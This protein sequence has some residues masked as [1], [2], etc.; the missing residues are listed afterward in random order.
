VTPFQEIAGRGQAAFL[1]GDMAEAERLFREALTHKPMSVGGMRGLGM[2]LV[3][4]SKF[5]EAEEVWRK[6]VELE[7][8][9]ADNHQLLGSVSMVIGKLAA[10]TTHLKRALELQPNIPGVAM[11]LANISYVNR[12]YAGAAGYYV[13]AHTEEPF[14]IEA[15]VG[16]VQALSDSGQTAKSVAVGMQGVARL[17]TRPDI[18]PK[19]YAGIYMTM[20]DAHKALKD[21]AAAVACYKTVIADDPTNS[22]AQHLLAA[23]EGHLTQDHAQGFAKDIFDSLAPSF[24]RRLV[25]LLKYRSPELLAQ[26][27]R[28][29]NPDATR[30][31]NVLDLGCGTGLMAKALQEVLQ[32]GKIVGVDLA[33][34]MIQE[35]EKRGIYSELVCRDVVDAMSARTER[36]DL[37]LAADVFIYVG[38]LSRVFALAKTLLLPG[39]TFAFTTEIGMGA[40]VELTS[41][42]HYR[43]SKAYIVRLATENGFAVVRATDAPIRKERGHDVMGHYVYLRA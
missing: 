37:I 10:A 20:A 1:S 17:R 28:E 15:L 26:G 42:G 2:A 3:K 8:Q 33:P 24:D 19:D 22:V 6:L 31:E 18:S 9:S 29:V 5:K 27:L 16:A 40:E 39:A 13:Q 34:K 41:Q 11:K 30:A 36:F 35:A 38:E 7:P 43:H 23:T 21:H 32:T 25:E 14:H 4:Q 12:D